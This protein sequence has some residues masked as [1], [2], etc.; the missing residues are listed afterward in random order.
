MFTRNILKTTL[1]AAS[2]TLAFSQI[3]AAQA[4]GLTSMV[5]GVFSA[6]GD[7]LKG[8]GDV[9]KGTARATGDVVKGTARVTG[10]A[11]KGTAKVAVKV[12]LRQFSGFCAVKI[13]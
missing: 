13:F 11:V 6:T 7:V 3:P 10:D 4:G 2:L 9:V 1:L 12:R 5:K 8:T